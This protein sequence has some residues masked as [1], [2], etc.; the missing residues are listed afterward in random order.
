MTP[1][2]HLILFVV[3]IP[4][5][6]SSKSD[7]GTGKKG[8]DDKKDNGRRVMDK[9]E[10]P[11]RDRKPPPKDDD[12]P[13]PAGNAIPI[14]GKDLAVAFRDGPEKAR[15]KYNGNLLE[16]TSLV[17]EMGLTATGEAYLTLSGCEE[18]LDTFFE[19]V[20]SEKEPWS[21]V[22]PEQT[23][24]LQGKCEFLGGQ[25]RL[26]DCKVIDATGPN[27]VKIIAADLVKAYE[28]DADAAGKQYDGKWVE[29]T[30]E[31]DRVEPIVALDT[32]RVLLKSPGKAAIS[33]GIGPGLG[34]VAKALKPGN[35]VRLVAKVR[36]FSAEE[37]LDLTDAL[38]Y[39]KP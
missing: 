2:K 11:P 10:G 26:R 18:P 1:S 8:D 15:A 35:P 9:D 30:G 7:D 19:C 22:L 25:L 3:L 29:L 5:G 17:K 4:L 34:P 13:A 20:A 39:A 24:K 36:K 14:K 27:R 28:K 38:I 6:C 33:C 37:G 12:N 23:V 21:K 31:V 16:V 32:F